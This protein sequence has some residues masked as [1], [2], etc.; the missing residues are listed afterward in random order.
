[1]LQQPCMLSSAGEAKK[2]LA[3]PW[4]S[5]GGE[6]LSL[7]DTQWAE[8]SHAYGRASD[9]PALLRQLYALP[10]ASGQEEPWFSLWSALAHQGDVYPHRLPPSLMWWQLCLM[11]L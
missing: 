1:M 2:S 11:I 3:M 9:I 5:M 8:L 7:D 4:V 10:H 6:M